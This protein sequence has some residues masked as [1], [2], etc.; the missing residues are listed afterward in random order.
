MQFVSHSWTHHH[1]TQTKRNPLACNCLTLIIPIPIWTLAL[2]MQWMSPSHICC[3]ILASLN[4]ANLSI[5]GRIT[6]HAQLWQFDNTSF[7]LQR[8]P[9]Y[10]SQLLFQKQAP[11][12][13]LKTPINFPLYFRIS[14]PF[15]FAQTI[16]LH[17]YFTLFLFAYVYYKMYKSCI[18][19]LMYQPK[20]LSSWFLSFLSHLS[21]SSVLTKWTLF[22]LI[23]TLGSAHCPLH[24]TWNSARCTSWLCRWTGPIFSLARHSWQTS[25]HPRILF[26]QHMQLRLDVNLFSSVDSHA[27]PRPTSPLCYVTSPYCSQLTHSSLKAVLHCSAM[28]HI[29]LKAVCS[30]PWLMPTKPVL[31]SEGTSY[32]NT[33]CIKGSCSM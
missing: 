1:L 16:Y 20:Y 31:G 29:T 14:N 28:T 33:I 9:L 15:L 30:L 18:K 32:C 8:I 6:N 12:K 11:Q 24:L 17:I 10:L 27:S 3:C 26:W 19:S 13:S 23:F 5:T 7:T 25:H 2:H 22:A 21:S 4:P